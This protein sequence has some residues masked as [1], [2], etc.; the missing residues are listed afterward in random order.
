V[1]APPGKTG[2][3][4]GE[5]VGVSL[6]KLVVV[7]VLVRVGELVGVDTPT[8]GEA[9]GRCKLSAGGAVRISGWSN[10]AGVGMQL[11]NSK[12][13]RPARNGRVFRRLDICVVSRQRD[14]RRASRHPLERGFV[15]RWAWPAG[16]ALTPKC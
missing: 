7:G 9:E 11:T 1:N 8:V 16:E 6:G 10:L 12:A 4:L 2:V 3:G 15:A 14:G 5:L 13:Q